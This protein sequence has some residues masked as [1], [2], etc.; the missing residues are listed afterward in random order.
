MFHDT[1]KWYTIWGKTE[2]W[3]EENLEN[4]MKNLQ[5]FTRILK[6]L[7]LEVWL[8]PFIHSKNFMNLKFTEDLCVMAM[9]N[10]TKLQ[11]GFTRR[12]KIDMRNLT[13]VDASTQ[14]SGKFALW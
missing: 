10:D 5:T 1:E 7:K 4:D 14:K 9:K 11:G 3:H 6:S 12:S 8:D 13:N 2:K